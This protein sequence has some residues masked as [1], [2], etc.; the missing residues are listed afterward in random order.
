MSYRFFSACFNISFL[1][2]LGFSNN[3]PAKGSDPLVAKI[4]KQVFA[5]IIS[6]G[7]FQTVNRCLFVSRAWRRALKDPESKLFL[8]EGQA[9]FST[10]VNSEKPYKVFKRASNSKGGVRRLASI[11]WV[12]PSWFRQLSLDDTD[13]RRILL[14]IK[15][16]IRDG[17][18]TLPIPE[19]AQQWL[20]LAIHTEELKLLRVVNVESFTSFCTR[21]LM[22]EGDK[23][24]NYN[25]FSQEFIE[26]DFLRF[27]FLE[28]C[29]AL[30]EKPIDL[31]FYVHSV[32][33]NLWCEESC[34]K[35]VEILGTALGA[36]Y[37]L[38]SIPEKT[39]LEELSGIHFFAMLFERGLHGDDGLGLGDEEVK[40]HVIE[41][42]NRLDLKKIGEAHGTALTEFGYGT[43]D[44]INGI[45]QILHAAKINLSETRLSSA[46][47]ERIRNIDI[48]NFGDTLLLN[49][50]D[51]EGVKQ[52]LNKG[53][54]Q[55]LANDE[56]DRRQFASDLLLLI[57]IKDY[58]SVKVYVRRFL[59]FGDEEVLRILAVFKVDQ[60]Y[61]IISVL[62]TLGAKEESLRIKN[63]YFETSG[64]AFG[65]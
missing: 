10:L 9:S 26:G 42:V 47:C 49:H 48:V 29:C 30:S 2:F 28:Y 55:N 45:L 21:L 43:N 24:L 57:A 56:F 53:L 46:I 16:A 44:G 61:R 35:Q 3:T 39:F 37:V 52:K 6:E 8:P 33:N 50:V 17:G 14:D 59:E 23:P 40:L 7:D 1:I 15:P 13:R 11:G 64:E 63:I 20:A 41:R 18:T 5:S 12:F 54:E 34:I 65:Y 38:D 4:P 27:T 36:Y 62:R 19:N 60:I 22:K 32:L 51:P 58:P 25:K 31:C